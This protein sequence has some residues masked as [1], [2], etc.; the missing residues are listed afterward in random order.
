MAVFQG[1]GDG[2]G[3][4][5]VCKIPGGSIYVY[6]LEVTD[7]NNRHSRGTPGVFYTY[8]YNPAHRLRLEKYYV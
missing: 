5:N 6:V 3:Y 4:K 1:G 8:F 7:I 2:R